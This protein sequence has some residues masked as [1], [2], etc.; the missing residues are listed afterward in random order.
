LQDSSDVGAVLQCCLHYTTSQAPGRRAQ[1]VGHCCWL[2]LGGRLV[3]WSLGSLAW[4]ALGSRQRQGRTIT[5][6]KERRRVLV[7][8]CSMDDDAVDWCSGGEVLDG[9]RRQ[10]LGL[11]SEMELENAELA[12]GCR[13]GPLWCCCLGQLPVGPFTELCCWAWNLKP[14]AALCKFGYRITEPEF[15]YKIS[16]TGSYYPNF[17]SGFAGSG[18]SGSGSGCSGS[19][20]GYRVFCPVLVKALSLTFVAWKKCRLK[21]LTVLG[22]C[23]LTTLM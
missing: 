5:G 17:F 6:R 16:G 14:W 9:R 20:F 15:S 13:T 21:S 8:V 4:S 22:L 10:L 1:G 19:G 18:F 2:L 3:G 23:I 12:G 7:L 11:E